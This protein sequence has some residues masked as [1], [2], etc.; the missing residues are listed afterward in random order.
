MESQD[1]EPNC[2]EPILINLLIFA[3]C[4]SFGGTIQVHFFQIIVFLASHIIFVLFIF[5]EA[6][7][8][9]RIKMT[10]FQLE[11]DQK[12]LHYWLNY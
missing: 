8:L 7:S 11:L 10:K 6:S 3:F 5:Y 4:W 1:L 12:N 9:G 2:G